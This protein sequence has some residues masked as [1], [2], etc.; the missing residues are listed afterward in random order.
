MDH[1]SNRI[2]VQSL[3]RKRESVCVCVDQ[4]T[5]NYRESREEEGMGEENWKEISK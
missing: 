1:K 2:W 3:L 5:E 4:S